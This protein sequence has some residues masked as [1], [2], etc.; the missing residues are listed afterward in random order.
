[1]CIKTKFQKE[2]PLGL[3]GMLGLTTRPFQIMSLD[4]IG[5]FGGNQSSN[6]YLHLLV[7]YFAR[8][9]YVLISANQTSSDM[10][11][12]IDLV[13]KKNPID[14]LLTDQYGGFSS[15]EFEDY[16]TKSNIEHVFVTVDSAFSNGLNERLGQT[17]VNRI[18]YQK[19]SGKS[20]KI[21]QPWLNHAS[22]N[23]IILYTLSQV[24]PLRTL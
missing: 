21:G 10:I 2:R 19:H 13:H 18:R 24:S 15:K 3:L 9:D 17:L 12:L 14:L 7:D 16:C 11:K 1:M 20:G 23:T 8:F 5:G 4:T 22:T 6:R